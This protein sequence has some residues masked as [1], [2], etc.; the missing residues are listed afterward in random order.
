MN[1]QTRKLTELKPYEKNPRK[2]SAAVDGVIKSIKIHGQVKPLVLSAPGHPFP[3]EIICCGH[4]TLKALQKMGVM[5]ARV[6]VHE[7]KSEDEFI[8]YNLRFMFHSIII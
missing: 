7:F 2:N 1:I 3:N 4:T 6:I 8:D 5:E